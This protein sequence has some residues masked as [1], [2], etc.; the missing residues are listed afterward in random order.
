MSQQTFPEGFLWGTATSAHQVEGNNHNDWSEWEKQNASRLAKESLGKFQHNSHWN[1]FRDQASDP[2]NYLSGRA[3]EQYT[4]YQ[5]DV[6]ILEQLHCNAY[7]FSLEWSRIEP[8]EGVFDYRALA[9]YREVIH[10]L[11]AKNIEPFI[12]L[13]HWTLP[14]WLAKKGGITS[15]DFAR[16]FTRYTAQVIHHLGTDTRFWITLNE[17]DVQSVHAY[18]NGV[19]PPQ[20]KSFWQYLRALHHLIQAHKQAYRILKAHA[21]HIQ[22]GIAKHQ[23]SFVVARPTLFNRLL[24]YGA[25]Y[26]WNHF[27]LKR[28]R[29]H[30]DFIGLNHYNRNVID[31]GFN[32][33]P[34][35]VQTDFGWEYCP[36]SIYQAL[37]ELKTYRKPIYITENGLADANDTLRQLFIPKALASV[38]QAINDGVDVRGYFYWSLLDNFEWDKGYWLRFGLVHVNYSTQKRTIRKSARYY[39]KVCQTNTLSPTEISTP[40]AQ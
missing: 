40:E 14:V 28:I 34:N 3:C 11:R 9:H 19:W 2:H 7:R 31:N 10:V 4:R 6:D 15:K 20:E 30:Q 8:Q 23:I 27:F 35:I 16:Y 25:D 22:V 32:K 26:G 36:S 37:I 18:W 13:W 21:P 17:P 33:N 1:K 24:K 38:H 12:T 39:A 29:R 5:E